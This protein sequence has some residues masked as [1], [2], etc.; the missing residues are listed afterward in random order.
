MASL[1]RSITR[2]LNQ[3]S[4]STVI[5]SLIN[6]R[7]QEK[8]HVLNLN[9][10]PKNK[11]IDVEVQIKD[12]PGP[13][14]VHVEGYELTSDQGQDQLRWSQITIDAGGA[15]LPPGIKDKLSYIM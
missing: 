1:L 3:A 9:I 4:G 12:Q 5:R 15:N 14:R 6:A 13:I 2:T 10:D 11:T 7:L 8:A